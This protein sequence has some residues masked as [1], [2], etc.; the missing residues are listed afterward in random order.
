[1]DAIK[2]LQKASDICFISSCIGAVG[3]IAYIALVLIPHNFNNAFE[4]IPVIYVFGLLI[5]LYISWVIIEGIKSILINQGVEI[6]N[7]EIENNTST[8][9]IE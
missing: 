5:M 3:A 6:E 8:E 9:I 1:M 2:H 4:I 7:E